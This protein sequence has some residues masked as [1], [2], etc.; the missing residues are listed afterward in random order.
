MGGTAG[1]LKFDTT[2]DTKG[3]K[4]GISQITGETKKGGGTI[5]NIVAGLG[6]AKI[7]SVGL[8]AIKD[9]LGSAIKRFDTLKNYP[10]VMES[11]GYSTD[12]AKKSINE[13]S[14]GIESLPTSL[15]EIVSSAQSYTATLGNMEKGT[16]TAIAVN[17]MLLA[18]GKSMDEVTRANE[19]Y[20]KILSKGKVEMDNWQSLVEVA[21]AQMD[22][23]AKSLLG[24]GANQRDL[25]DA[26]RDGKISMEDFN[27]EV[28]RLDK[29]GGANFASFK[30][31]AKSATE[32]IATS[33]QNIKT[34]I[35]KN[36][37]NI[38]GSINDK[39]EELG[40]GTIQEN[41]DKV[42]GFIND[43][44]KKA[45]EVIPKMIELLYKLRTPIML[46]VG[47]LGAFKLGMAGITIGKNVVERVGELKSKFE[48]LQKVFPAL[49][50]SKVG[51]MLSSIGE[52]A[53][54]SASKVLEFAKAHKGLAIGLGVAGVAIGGMIALYKKSGGDADK[55]S[56]MITSKIEQITKVITDIASKLPAIINK[57]LPKIIKVFTEIIPQLIQTIT[58]AIPQVLPVVVNGLVTLITS[59]VSS[60]PVLIPPLINGLI[61][62]VLALV[63]MIPVLIPPLI[64]G[65]IQIIMALVRAL[66]TIIKALITA[67][68]TIITAIIGGLLKCLPQLIIGAIQ[69]VI[70][71]VKALPQIIK[72]LIK[73][74]PFII[75]QLVQALI[76]ASVGMWKAGWQMIKE[77]WNGIKQKIPETKQKIKEFAKSLPGKI[78]EGISDIKD[79]GINFVKGLWNGIKSVKDW[80]L[81]RIREFGSSVLNGLKK[82]L[83]IKSP[84]RATME[85]GVNF[86]LGMIKG[87]EASKKKVLKSVDMFGNDILSKMQNAVA[88]ETG[89][90]NA[91]ATLRANYG[92]TIVVN[93]NIQADVIMDRTKVG[94]AVTP[95]VSQTLKKAG[96]R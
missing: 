8:N 58:T 48:G 10:R 49:Q 26:L 93:S 41:L 69:L 44:G 28:I 95:V 75:K 29:E 47:A 32:G 66:P 88:L 24:A 59:L 79:I 89:N 37:A 64:K 11:L 2:L 57:V 52:Q 14:D 27:N 90:I 45:Q 20:N 77:L 56:E 76:Q 78:K 16:K 86:D 83:K 22:Q 94:Q 12:E 68:P 71:L 92:Q 43:V 9:S 7:A 13:L 74:A 51:N 21:P 15:D 33:F 1:Y 80:I 87:I 18:S 25:Y 82:I 55:M 35:V 38:I 34:A 85:I 61:Q 23:L 40:I 96:V 72:S 46:I 3:F 19:A 36:V 5:K 60:I 53:K 81:S 67:L 31:Q 63:S 84:S 73:Q 62:I 4:S 50:N 17:D 91:S 65:A 70:G 39:L 42:K 54:G 6:I 30:K